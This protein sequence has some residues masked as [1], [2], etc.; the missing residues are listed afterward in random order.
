MDDGSGLVALYPPLLDADYF[1]EHR[2]DFACIVRYGINHPIVVND[3]PFTTPMEGIKRIN[4]VEIAN[5]FNFIQ[6][7]W[8]PE[9]STLSE[10]EV[11]EQLQRC[12]SA[13]E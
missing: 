8:Y 2:D 10:K 6:S 11:K 7:S 13:A 1:R 5:I 9:L 12:A 3:V 4:E